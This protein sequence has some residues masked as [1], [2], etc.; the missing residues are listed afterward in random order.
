MGTEPHPSGPRRRGKFP[1]THWTL[2]AEAGRGTGE[3]KRQAMAELI[4]AY[5][6]A[7][8]SYLTQTRR[9]DADR[10]DDLLQGFLT[11]KVLEDDLIRRAEQGRGRFRSFLVSSLDRFVLNTFRYESAGVRSPGRSSGSL[12]PIA[13]GA[14]PPARSP[15]PDVAFDVAWAREVLANTVELMRE[16]C[17]AGARPDVWGIFEGRVLRPTLGQ[18]EQVPY[19]DLVEQFGFASPAHASNALVTAN[20]MF[21]RVLRRVIGAYELDEA[22][23]DD[24]IADL[25]RILSEF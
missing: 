24:E 23:I 13:D 5:G 15:A 11:D 1:T 2:V 25:R 22:A 8:R 12:Q 16:Q 17:E 7:L 9:V 14:D 18:M 3:A 19:T 21:V 6:P 4:E 10:A 20:R